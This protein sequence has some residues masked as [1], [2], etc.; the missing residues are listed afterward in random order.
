MRL[1]ILLILTGCSYSPQSG[2]LAG[3]ASDPDS[4]PVTCTTVGELACDGR[5][6]RECGPDL[7]WGEP[8]VCGFTCIAGA[9][10]DASNVADAD[11]AGCSAAAPRLAPT[12]GSVIVT[13]PNGQ[14][15]LVCS[16]GC[17]GELMEILATKVA[18]SP[19][20]GWFCLSSIELPSGVSL[21]LPTS[22]GPREA[23]AFVVNGAVVIDG[24]INFDG[25]AA[26]QGA[27]G[28]G[29][30]GAD[31]GGG[32]AS[33][34]GGSGLVG[35]GSGGGQGGLVTG[36]ANNFAAGG[37]GGGG[38]ETPGGG[39]G[40][41]QSPMGG[42]SMGGQGGIGFGD[43]DLDPLVGGSGGGGGGD[44]S[45]GTACGWPGGGGG[46]ALQISSRVSISIGGQI[47]ARGGDGFG[48]AAN[49]NGAG[50]AG[51]GG[52]GGAFLLEAPSISTTG[53]IVVD[54]G[55]GGPSSAGAGG[56]GASGAAVATAGSTATGTSQGGAGGG[57]AS[58]R[59]RIRAAAPSCAAVSP[60]AACT[61][62]P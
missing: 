61:T 35:R 16:D 18:G 55:N 21:G 17:D 59:V 11:V 30:P 51:G 50:G 15:K 12:T 25:R 54:G 42:T 2:S 43:P 19:G 4:L 57:G 45:C 14:T 22:G 48:F 52:A 39:G 29:A 40:G 58:G 6:R 3:D 7:Q 31:D 46:G 49:P 38:F 9:C 60:A 20:L 33:D 41:G 26:T 5:A 24:T 28:K 37:G 34:G 32:P 56:T 23:I 53:T 62:Q 8:E 47:R 27:G 36:S 1:A 44:G 10:V 13:A